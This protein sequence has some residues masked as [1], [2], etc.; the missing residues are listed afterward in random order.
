MVVVTEEVVVAIAAPTTTFGRRNTKLHSFRK[1][2]I[3]TLV[4][5]LKTFIW[6]KN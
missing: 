4:S 3:I 1:D 5:V 6:V 2:R